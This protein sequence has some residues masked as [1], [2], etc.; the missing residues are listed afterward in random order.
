[1]EKIPVYIDCDGVIIDTIEAAKRIAKRLGYDPDDYDS[2]HQYFLHDVNWKEII[3]E[4]GIIGNIVELIETLSKSEKY[5]PCIL[6]KFSLETLGKYEVLFSTDSE[7]GYSIYDSLM[8]LPHISDFDKDEASEFYKLYFIKSLFQNVPIIFLGSK[9]K[10]DE[11]V[12]AKGA[13]LIEDE[14][15]NFRSWRK[16]GGT[17]ILLSR[18]GSE[19]YIYNYKEDK[20][21]NPITG[22]EA[23][24]VVTRVEDF[25]R[26][27]CVKKLLKRKGYSTSNRNAA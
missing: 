7:D 22:E 10:K 24:C 5:A 23:H 21:H 17:A 6:T 1:M 26:T 12:E 9:Y 20:E 18:G 14:I 13:I 8:T 19:G 27:R 11:I 3:Q 2:M 25:E 15:R 4:G 16:K